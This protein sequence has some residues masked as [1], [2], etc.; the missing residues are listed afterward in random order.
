MKDR[1]PKHPGRVELTPVSGQDGVFDMTMADEAFEE[2][3]P[4]IKRHLLPD[5]V[6]QMFDAQNPPQDVGEALERAR[7]LIGN[8]QTNLNTHANATNPHSGSAPLASPALTG[9]PTAPTAAAT[10]NN[11]QIATTAFAQPRLFAGTVAQVRRGDHSVQAIADLLVAGAGRITERPI[12]NVNTWLNGVAQGV[13]WA[14]SP[15]AANT[16]VAGVGVFYIGHVLNAGIHTVIR[17][18]AHTGFE[19]TRVLWSG[20]W[21]A[22]TE[23][24]SAPRV[25]IEFSPGFRLIR[26]GQLIFADFLLQGTYY[27]GG[28]HVGTLPYGYRPILGAGEVNVIIS[29][30]AGAT[31]PPR[32]MRIEVGTGIVRNHGTTGTG[33]FIGNAAWTT[34]EVI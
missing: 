17:A 27:G 28:A 15:T 33:I 20:V 26:A 5:E 3:T 1:I 31:V 23:T 21:G 2:G 11:T 25:A 34:D 14:Y 4:P 9:T 16:P 19:Y 7:T 29:P 6:A 30:T 24:S 18:I 12:T 13:Y 8:V 22:W 32:W 10:V